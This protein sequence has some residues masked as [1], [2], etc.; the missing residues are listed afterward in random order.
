M[1]EKQRS[2]VHEFQQQVR[3][4]FDSRM[5]IRCPHRMIQTPGSWT[6]ALLVPIVPRRYP[7]SVGIGIVESCSRCEQKACV[8]DYGSCTMLHCDGSPQRRSNVRGPFEIT[9]KT[10]QKYSIIELGLK[11]SSPALI[12]PLWS[13]WCRHVDVISDV[14]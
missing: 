8:Q 9:P 7:T 5:K 12:G 1:Q 11:P 6:A 4:P 3:G 2:H 13:T 14:S 10:Q